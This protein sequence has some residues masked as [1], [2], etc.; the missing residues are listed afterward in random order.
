MPMENLSSLASKV[1][2]GHEFYEKFREEM[3]PEQEI[4]HLKMN[5]AKVLVSIW[6]YSCMADG[7]FHQKEGSLVGQMVKALFEEGCIF[8]DHQSEKTSILAELSDVFENP[9]PVKT[10]R[11]FSEGNPIMAAG[12]YEDACVIVSMDGALTKKEKEFL[13]D[14]AKELEISSMDK[15][16]I[17]SRILGKKK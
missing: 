9:L 12:F 17:E 10:V 14:L 3:N 6:S 2:P 16:N 1:L 13:D 8:F 11:N 5:Y 15:K 4:F 7:I